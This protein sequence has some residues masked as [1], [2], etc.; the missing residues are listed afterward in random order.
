MGTDLIPVDAPFYWLH[1]SIAIFGLFTLVYGL[2]AYVYKS[3][4][5][6]SEVV[7]ATVRSC[8]LPPID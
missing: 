3:K 5:F 1:A 8:C 4:L 2:A 7:I 6:L